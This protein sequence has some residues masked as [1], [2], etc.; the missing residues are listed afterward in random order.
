MHSRGRR[1]GRPGWDREREP[2]RVQEVERHPQKI[3]SGLEAY[4]H[5]PSAVHRPRTSAV[6]I[7]HHTCAWCENVCPAPAHGSNWEACDLF[8]VHGPTEG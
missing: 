5:F 3:A 7:P 4:W 8:L 2:A 6:F 1:A